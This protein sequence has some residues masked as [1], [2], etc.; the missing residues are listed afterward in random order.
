MTTELTFEQRYNLVR[1]FNP[2]TNLYVVNP[3]ALCGI[4]RIPVAGDCDQDALENICE[5]LKLDET[6]QFN[7]AVKD[8]AKD[9]G[10]TEDAAYE[11][12][13]SSDESWLFVNGGST[14]VGT[15]DWW[16]KEA[17]EKTRAFVRAWIKATDRIEE[18]GLPWE[19]GKTWKDYVTSKCQ[20]AA[21]GIREAR[22]ILGWF[23]KDP[24]PAKA[25]AKLLQDLVWH[26][27]HEKLTD[28]NVAVMFDA[29]HRI[30]NPEIKVV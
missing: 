7:E 20:G 26:I 4:W 12:E 11:K 9:E 8:R 24:D 19:E 13:V 5:A 25:G 21:D 3:W 29:A 23:F 10:I 6:A 1:D 28:E 17:G 22:Y 15:A 27:E 14:I 30:F 18:D 2:H 16:Y